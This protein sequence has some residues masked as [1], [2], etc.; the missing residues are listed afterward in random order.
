MDRTPR[1]WQPRRIDVGVDLALLRRA[2]SQFYGRPSDDYLDWLYVRNPAGMPF[3]H[4]AMDGDVIAGQ[5]VVIPIDMVARGQS[6]KAC[7]SL[8]TFTHEGYRRQGIF[9]GLAEAVFRDVRAAGCRFTLGFPNARSHHGLVKS[10][11]FEEPFG[12]YLLVKPLARAA[13]GAGVGRVVP[14]LLGAVARYSRLKI[15][16]PEVVES[17][18]ID[19]LWGLRRAV[20]S[21]GFAKTGTWFRWRFDGNPRVSYRII[22][23]TRADGEPA[24]VLVWSKDERA[25]RRPAVNL[26][27]LEATG[28]GVRAALVGALLEKIAGEADFVKAFVAPVSELGRS[29]LMSGFVPV[30]RFPFNYRAHSA[31]EDLRPAL[32]ATAWSVSGAYADML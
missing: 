13:L 8:D 26:V 6:F 7:L 2:R 25:G 24:G 21:I 10:L 12:V 3:C 20:T 16:T 29:L 15:E 19:R 11:H 22:T 28:H 4:L 27:D 23:A 31:D 32:R 14:S 18:W 17:D 5:Y 1:R 30:R 9:K